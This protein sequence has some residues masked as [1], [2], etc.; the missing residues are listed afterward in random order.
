[1]VDVILYHYTV[2]L[3]SHIYTLTCVYPCILNALLTA[4]SGGGHCF[5]KARFQHIQIPA[6]HI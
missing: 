4:G 3:E 2:V 6:R 5:A 1:M